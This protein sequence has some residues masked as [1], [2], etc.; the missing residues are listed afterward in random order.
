M[1]HGSITGDS[2]SH[3]IFIGNTIGIEE[4]GERITIGIGDE[5]NNEDRS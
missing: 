3:N 1:R 4:E 2:D 5:R